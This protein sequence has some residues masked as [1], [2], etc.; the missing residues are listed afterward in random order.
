MEVIKTNEAP[1][2]V[3]PYSQAVLAGSL[4]FLSGQIALDPQTGEMVQDSIE[5]ETQRVLDNIEAI[6]L[7]AR[8]SIRD[9]VK[10]TVYATDINDF[11]AIN[12]VYAKTFK[13]D[14]PAR[15]FVQVAALPKCARV[16]IEV[17]ARR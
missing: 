12:G 16:E 11:A 3:G 7:E 4:L 17:I 6:L 1:Q 14:P 15:S 13:V 2:A 8:F 5:A 9:V 10:T